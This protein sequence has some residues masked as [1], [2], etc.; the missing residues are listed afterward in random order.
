MSTITLSSKYPRDVLANEL[1]PLALELKDALSSVEPSVDVRVADLE[2]EHRVGQTFLE[3][4]LIAL[5]GV[6]GLSSLATITD[7]VGKW[8]KRRSEQKLDRRPRMA[9]ILGPDGKVVSRVRLDADAKEPRII[10]IDER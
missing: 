8:M 4:V 7:T 10:K 9:E 5:T 6:G 2:D 3:I 1:E